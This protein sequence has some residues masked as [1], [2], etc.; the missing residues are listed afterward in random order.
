MDL[1][2]D[3]YDDWLADAV[4]PSRCREDRCGYKMPYTS[5]TTGRPKGVVMRGSGTTTFATG[6]AGIA[7]WAEA[8]ELPGDGVHLFCSRLFNGAPQTFGFG[9]TGPRRDAADPA[10]LGCRRPRS[11]S[12]VAP[13]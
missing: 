12:S 4:R 13:T 7:H 11:P 2:A 3:G 10:P 6:W 9:A 8:L 5:G 1:D